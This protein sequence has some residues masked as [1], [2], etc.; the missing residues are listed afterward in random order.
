VIADRLGISVKTVKVHR[1]HIMEKMGVRSAAELLHLCHLAG[2]EPG[3]GS[4]PENG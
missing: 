1:A 2:I 4:T 3:A